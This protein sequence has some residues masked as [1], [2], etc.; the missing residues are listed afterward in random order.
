VQGTGTTIVQVTPSGQVSLFA[1]IN[2]NLPAAPA[3]SA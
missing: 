1:R 3:A 2:P